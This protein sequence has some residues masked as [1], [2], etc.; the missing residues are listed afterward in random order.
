M[1]AN[2]RRNPSITTKLRWGAE[3]YIFRLVACLLQMLTARQT[4]WLAGVL[5]DIIM[6]LP[7]SWT[8]Y[9]I[10]R[11]NI[12]RAFAARD[13]GCAIRD[14]RCGDPP[15]SPRRQSASPR[16]QSGDDAG[17]DAGCGSPPA[18]PR[19]QS[20]SPRRQSGDDAGRDAGCGI[21]DTGNK[22]E[23]RAAHPASRIP[24]PA[25]RAPDPDTIIRGMWVHL[26]RMTA[27]V[28]QLPRKLALT[29]CREVIVFRNRKVVMEAIGTGRPLIVLGGHF[30]N[31]EVSAAQFGLF[32]IRMGVIGRELDNPHLHEWFARA[33]ETTGHRLYLKKGASDEMV[34]LLEAGGNLALACDQ[35]AGHKGMFVDFFGRPASTF[36]SIALMAMQYDAIIVVGYGLRLPDDFENS[37]W[38]RFEIGCEEVIDPRTI[39]ARDE[40]REITQRYTAALE[41]IVRRAPEQYF[42]VHRRWKTEPDARRQVRALRKA[43]KAA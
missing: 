32:G 25:S 6:R 28:V 3:Y 37:R 20:A 10:A 29:N 41:R 43:R 21:R 17:R 33:R 16:R 42:W 38:S 34:R 5:A 30:G 11:D 36:K 35:D 1:N 2:E 8:R 13:A 40:L 18:S 31:W 14:A 9:D 24:N 15:A 22:N 26:F 19:R 4:A 39:E 23:P 27:E 12:E 7:A